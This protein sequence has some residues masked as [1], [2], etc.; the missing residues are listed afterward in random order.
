MVAVMTALPP[1]L[2][3]AGPTA[4][5]KSALAL[6]AAAALGGE[7]VN[8]D[9]TQIYR[10][11]RILSA[12]PPPEEVAQAP[13]HLFGVVDASEAWSVGRWQ[14]AALEVLEGIAARGRTAIVVGGTG[15]YL[16]ALTHGLADIP[17]PPPAVRAAAR[18]AYDRDGEAAFRSVL[19]LRDPAAE[20]R[21]MSG[22]RQRLLRAFEVF[23]ATGRALTDW[24]RQT[25]P[26]LAP[27]AWRAVV[28]EP[29]RPVLYARCDARLQAMIEAGALDEVA[30]LM[31]RGLDPLLP[32]MKAVGLRELAAHLRG[33]TDLATALALAQQE[34]RRF[35]KRQSTWFRNQTPDWPRAVGEEALDHG[36]ICRGD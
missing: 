2:I 19:R 21:I 15:L 20:T 17:Q 28:L 29:P 25:T 3:V 8:A 36:R 30:T 35:A 31:A 33:E 18:A 10:D 12:R 26:P 32:I 6:R 23:E 4:S 22:D 5:G 14:A 9:A 7:I 16:R 13:H 24:Q 27:G 34:T 11:L 1:I